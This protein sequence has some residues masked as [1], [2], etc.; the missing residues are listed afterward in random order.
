MP[1]SLHLC[2]LHTKL[3]LKLQLI[4]YNACSAMHVWTSTRKFQNL[5][6]K[7]HTSKR[8]ILLPI[9]QNIII[10]YQ[11]LNCFYQSGVDHLDMQTW[12][13]QKYNATEKDKQTFGSHCRCAPGT[14]RDVISIV[15]QRSIK[16]VPV[17]AKRR[18]RIMNLSAA[19]Q[20][21]IVIIQPVK[22]DLYNVQG[23]KT[24]LAHK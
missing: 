6:F 8:N 19:N 4:L 18:R 24:Y 12:T 22:V 11:Y 2:I 14:E 9:P 17:K 15:T 16:T 3:I 1:F 7:Y 13:Q 21:Q 20:A 23:H 5:N 10:Y